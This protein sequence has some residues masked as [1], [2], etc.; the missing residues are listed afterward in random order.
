MLLSFIVL[1]PSEVS[2][3]RVRRCS[4]YQSGRHQV[5]GVDIF[6]TYGQ[7]SSGSH[8]GSRIVLH[9]NRRTFDTTD[10][11]EGFAT[12]NALI[13]SGVRRCSLCAYSIDV[14]SLHHSSTT[15]LRYLGSSHKGDE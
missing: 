15:K 7:K 1:R 11:G 5:S 3:I 2:Y 12:P 8:T 6:T 9:L 14:P 10:C 13:T 4:T